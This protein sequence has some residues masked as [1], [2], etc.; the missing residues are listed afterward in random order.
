MS[1]KQIMW[2]ISFRVSLQSLSDG[3]NFENEVNSDLKQEYF[4]YTH[5]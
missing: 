3:D 5:V 4:I 1:S 2:I